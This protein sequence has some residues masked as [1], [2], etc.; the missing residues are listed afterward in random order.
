MPKLGAGFTIHILRRFK[1]KNADLVP[2]EKNI[3]Q[4]SRRKTHEKRLTNS[5]APLQGIHKK[6]PLEAG[7]CL[8]P[9]VLSEL[10]KGRGRSYA[11]RVRTFQPS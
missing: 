2:R 5:Y 11:C 4:R 10:F 6:T 3:W 1:S 8:E 9:F 7:F